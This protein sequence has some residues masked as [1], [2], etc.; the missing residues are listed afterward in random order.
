MVL[1]FTGSLSI[2][3]ANHGDVRTMLIGALGCNLAWGFIDGVLYLMG[4]LAEKGASLA[5][6]CALRQAS[7]PKQAHRLI[8]DAV[9]SSLASVLKSEDLEMLRQRLCELNVPTARP[10]LTAGDWLGAFA[11]FLWVFLTTF[12]VAIPFIFMSNPVIAMRLSNAIA[13][14][15]LFLAGFAYARYL[16]RSP[17]L[18]GLGMVALGGLLVGLTIALGG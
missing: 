3:E 15:M 17:W 7:D 6:L 10:Q 2:A 12:P 11:V 4:S 13:I 9:P 8:A 16:G 1:T 18:V 5:M 14:A